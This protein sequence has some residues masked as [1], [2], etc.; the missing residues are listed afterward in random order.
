MIKLSNNIYGLNGGIAG[1]LHPGKWHEFGENNFFEFKTGDYTHGFFELTPNRFALGYSYEKNGK[2]GLLMVDKNLDANNAEGIKMGSWAWSNKRNIAFHMCPTPDASGFHYAISTQANFDNREVKVYLQK[3]K[4]SPDSLKANPNISSTLVALPLKQPSERLSDIGTIIRDSATNYIFD[5]L[6][7]HFN[8]NHS[9]VRFNEKGNLVMVYHSS[10]SVK[11][12]REF[13]AFMELTTSGKL[14]RIDTLCTF[15]R[16][17]FNSLKLK[18]DGF[19][20]YMVIF[21][22]KGMSSG[23]NMST[24]I[25]LFDEKTLELKRK[26]TVK[27]EHSITKQ[28]CD[29]KTFNESSITIN[30]GNVVAM[31]PY[32]KI[33]YYMIMLV[34]GIDDKQKSRILF[35]ELT[36][37]L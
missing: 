37:D 26:L 16:V 34:N 14:V 7:E 8:P 4:F 1:F 27:M 36:E 25:L 12:E 30:V 10:R 35:A 22:D 18:N 21:Q 29:E 20:N 28:V 32:S 3:F 33:K 17:A 6:Y 5:A 23:D 2:F 9:I 11:R 31:K 24:R 15:K 19:G 13:V